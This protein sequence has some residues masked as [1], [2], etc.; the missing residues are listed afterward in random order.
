MPNI[1][2]SIDEKLYRQAR[3]YAV[4]RNTTVTQLLRNF[5]QETIPDNYR[6]EHH[7]LEK[8]LR[9][10]PAFIR[11]LNPTPSPQSTV[12]VRCEPAE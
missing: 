8:L 2:I 7:E 4:S 12:P 10:Y 6:P 1:T 5:L 11:L 3:I 9:R